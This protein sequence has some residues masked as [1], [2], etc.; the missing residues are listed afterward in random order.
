MASEK[1]TELELLQS[2]LELIELQNEELARLRNLLTEGGE[3]N[4]RQ[5]NEVKQASD[6]TG[7]MS[8][9]L[10]DSDEGIDAALKVLDA[11]KQNLSRIDTAATT[12]IQ[13]FSEIGFSGHI[14]GEIK[15]LSNAVTDANDVPFI[16]AHE[17]YLRDLKNRINGKL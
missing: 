6:R 3:L 13:K 7:E 14:T 8:R 17:R 2:A 10:T 1:H 5:L 16:E 12:A 11:M 9:L 15:A 4:R